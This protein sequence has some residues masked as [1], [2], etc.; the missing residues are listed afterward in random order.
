MDYGGWGFRFG[1]FGKGRALNVSGNKGI[2]LVLTD[3]TRLLIGTNKPD[4]AR[5]ALQ[6][7]GHLAE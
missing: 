4:E 7:I 1:L 2:Q 6:L 3:G 5:Q